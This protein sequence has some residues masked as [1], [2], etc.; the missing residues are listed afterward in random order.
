[1]PAPPQVFVD[2][3][4]AHRKAAVAVRAPD[5]ARE[6]LAR[7]QANPALAA[8]AGDLSSLQRLLSGVG[9]DSSGGEEDSGSEAGEGVQR[10]RGPAP[11]AAVLPSGVAAVLEAAKVAESVRGKE[12]TRLAR[13]ARRAEA[14]ERREQQ[15]EGGPV[16]QVE[17]RRV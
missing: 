8:A 10:G 9:S 7:L 3:A 14:R 2:P 16:P 11:V 13:M 17:G 4:T 15:Q 5:R 6:A 1:M 12:A